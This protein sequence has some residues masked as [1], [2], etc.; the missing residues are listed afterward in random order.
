MKEAAYSPSPVP[1]LGQHVMPNLPAG[2]FGFRPP[3]G[4]GK[5]PFK[6]FFL[7]GRY[8]EIY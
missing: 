3:W 8:D 6:I 7:N 2:R 5:N 1:H 4:G